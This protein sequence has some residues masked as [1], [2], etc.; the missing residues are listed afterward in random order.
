MREGSWDLCSGSPDTV[1]VEVAVTVTVTVKANITATVTVIVKGYFHTH[2]QIY[3]YLGLFPRLRGLWPMDTCG[4][5]AEL[6][7]YIDAYGECA[8]PTRLRY[9]IATFCGQLSNKFASLEN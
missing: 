1:T 4:L 3:L 5:V 8:G 2:I 6:A 7:H 9:S